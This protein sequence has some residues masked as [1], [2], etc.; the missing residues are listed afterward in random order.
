MTQPAEPVTFV[1]WMGIFMMG[2][3]QALHPQAAMGASFGCFFF[4]AFPDRG[5]VGR[6]IL[7][8]VFSWGIGYATGTGVAVSPD[9]GGYAMASA[10]VCSALASAVFGVVNLM[11]R[12]DGPMPKWLDN[13]L[14][15]IPFLR[16][17]SDE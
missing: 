15:R 16:R 4:L 10:V 17:H 12:N 7:L 11:I 2:V 8:L 14:N 1:V 3:F 9:W 6:K 13:V 5:G